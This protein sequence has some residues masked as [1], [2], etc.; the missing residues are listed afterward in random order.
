[1]TPPGGRPTAR[2]SSPVVWTAAVTFLV[3]MGLGLLPPALPRIAAHYDVSTAEVA[4]LLTAFALGRLV[5]SL[6]GGMIADRLGFK[7]VAVV[8]CAVTAAG[9]LYAV[10]LPSF[11][12]LVA[13]QVVQ[14]LGSALYTTA[15]LAAIL[16]DAPEHR[17]GRVTALYQGVILA[18][19]TSAPAIGGLAVR[20]LGL[21]GPFLVYGIAAGVGL[22]ISVWRVPSVDAATA[23]RADGSS[24]PGGEVDRRRLL[25]ELLRHRAVPLVLA[26]S[27]GVFWVVSGVRN[28]LIPVFAETVLGLGPVA[29]GWLLTAAG[30]GSL[31]VL[32]HAGR[33]IDRGRRPVLVAGTLAMAVSVAALALAVDPWVLAGVT[34]L[35]GVTRGYAGVVPVTVIV[36]VA[37]R[38]VQ[39][40]AIGLQR[41]ATGLGL[42]V[43]PYTAGLLVDGVG[44]A[45]TFVG[46]GA[47]LAGLALLGL[48]T[49]ETGVAP[50]VTRR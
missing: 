30:F 29:S 46:V 34:L 37:D 11:W 25:A 43:G 36:D 40:T 10:T 26:L 50:P 12:A 9:A 27:F 28:T 32:R 23:A 24:E 8:G 3:M 17:I 35:L 21:P 31:A 39:G 48:R 42:T 13:A 6:P 2:A 14:G 49:P 20:F 33:A 15:A 5:F 16:A 18:G 38:R 1:M 22:A 45:A 7:R 44:Y 41:T 19:M 47:V 4:L